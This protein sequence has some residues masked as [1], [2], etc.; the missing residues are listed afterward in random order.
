MLKQRY[1]VVSFASEVNEEEDGNGVW[2]DDVVLAPDPAAALKFVLTIRCNCDCAHAFTVDDVDALGGRIDAPTE[3]V[4]KAMCDMVGE[5][6]TNAG[7]EQGEIDAATA[8]VGLVSRIREG[9]IT[10]IKFTLHGLGNQLTEIDGQE[11]A[12][13]WDYRQFNG[14][15]KVGARVRYRAL[16]N[17][18][19]SDAPLL[20]MDVAEIMEA[21]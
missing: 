11:W 12:T 3:T 21:L 1:L 19:V 8:A 10:N 6:C 5:W 4:Q 18:K 14:R 9:T 2:Y 16:L 7:P 15:I 20:H 17:E 13:W